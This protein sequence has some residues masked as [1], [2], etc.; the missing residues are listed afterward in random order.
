M[1]KI[2]ATIV[3][4]SKN[5]FGNRLTTYV[6]TF[7]RYIL[8]ELNTH[9]MLSKNSA[10]SRAIPFK[11]MVQAVIDNPFIP[12]AWMKDH[13]GM[14]GSEYFTEIEAEIIKEDWLHARDSAV[15]RAL[16]LNE[17]GL[18][19]Q[20]VNRVLEPYMWHTVILS[21]TEFENFFSLRCSEYADI[22]IQKLAYEM[23]EA[24]NASTPKLLKEGEWHIPFGDKFDEDKLH[25]LAFAQR[26]NTDE[27]YEVIK[28]V[29][30][31]KIAIAR[32][33]RVSYTVVGEEGKPDNYENDIK[34][35]DRLA[36]SGHYSP[37]EHVG[38]AM[39][40]EEYAFKSSY[41]YDL[42]EPKNEVK[43]FVEQNE[44]PYKG[45]WGWSGNFRGFIQ[46]R[47]TLANENRKDARVVQK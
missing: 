7:P 42:D 10:S 24:Y 5:Q 43:F 45:T 4:D 28:N 34:L 30:K 31:I 41:N 27:L 11:K 1:T 18:T 3:A 39:N 25:E 16:S 19:K 13:S 46:Y 33:A 47:K 12:I 6:L 20:L 44:V 32:C 15:K 36:T 2:S 23:L 26:G 8:A 38:R 9:R 37:F 22:H 17:K 29:L 40:D 21:G 35:F 14:Q